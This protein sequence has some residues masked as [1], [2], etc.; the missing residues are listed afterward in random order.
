[1]YRSAVVEGRRG[2]DIRAFRAVKATVKEFQERAWLTIP[3]LG[4]SFGLETEEPSPTPDAS[5]GRRVD[6]SGAEAGRD[7]GTPSRPNSAM[8]DFFVSAA[9]DDQ[10]WGSW[11]AWYLTKEGYTVRL[12][13]WALLAGSRSVEVLNEALESSKRTIAVLSPAYLASKQVQTAWGNAWLDDPAGLE[14]TLIPVRVAP[15]E[16]GGLL[17]GI[18]YIDLVGLREDAARQ[19]LVEQIRRAVDGRYRPTTAPPFPGP[20]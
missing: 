20:S 6:A 4:V 11:I 15:C 9:E 1:M 12:E 7:P 13:S 8:R 3:E 19:Y 2:L 17:R 14:R 10:G 5:A 16:P 18:R